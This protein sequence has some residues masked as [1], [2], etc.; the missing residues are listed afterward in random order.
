MDIKNSINYLNDKLSKI[1]YKDHDFSDFDELVIDRIIL[2][3]KFNDKQEYIDG[4]YSLLHDKIAYAHLIDKYFHYYVIN[5]DKENKTAT[6]VILGYNYDDKL[7]S[8]YPAVIEI[9]H[10]ISI[11]K[12]VMIT[13]ENELL[14]DNIFEPTPIIDIL[15]TKGVLSVHLRTFPIFCFNMN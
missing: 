9:L 12:F 4:I 8:Y 2:S 10:D 13:Y 11:K 7:K 15:E 14:Y 6:I 5:Y 1:R 3:L